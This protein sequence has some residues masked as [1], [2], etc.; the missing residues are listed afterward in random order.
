MH[1][2]HMHLDGAFLA[3]FLLFA[4]QIE[5]LCR[6]FLHQKVFEDFLRS[7]VVIDT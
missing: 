1:V 4:R 6:T 7:H 2:N 5:L 3:V